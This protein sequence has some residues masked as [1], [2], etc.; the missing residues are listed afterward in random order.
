MDDEKI[1]EK[2]HVVRLFSDHGTSECQIAEHIWSR[3][4]SPA[5]FSM[6]RDS[7][8]LQSISGI[9]VS[10]KSPIHL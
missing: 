6:P 4:C 1:H 7:C 2:V 10:V 5:Q 8:E 3:D 9:E